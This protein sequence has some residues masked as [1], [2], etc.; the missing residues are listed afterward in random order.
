MTTFVEEHRE[1]NAIV[2]WLAA[3]V[4]TGVIGFGLGASMDAGSPSIG[5]ESVATE[6]G[7]HPDWHGNVKR[8]QDW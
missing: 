7:S 2:L 3:L 6:T 8:S 1:D 5:T 4:L